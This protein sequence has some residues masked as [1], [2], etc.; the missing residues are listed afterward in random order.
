MACTFST[1]GLED[2]FCVLL[3][4]ALCSRVVDRYSIHQFYVLRV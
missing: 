1:L 2:V 4:W 3:L